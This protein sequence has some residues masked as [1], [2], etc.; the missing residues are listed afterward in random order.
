ARYGAPASCVARSHVVQGATGFEKQFVDI[1]ACGA[2]NFHCGHLMGAASQSL[3]GTFQCHTDVATAN[4]TGEIQ[5]YFHL[6][7]EAQPLAGKGSVPGRPSGECEL[8]SRGP[9]FVRKRRTPNARLRL[10]LPAFLF[11]PVL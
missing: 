7:H 6:D 1:M 11:G 8:W 3:A 4:T 9:E 5:D 10:P 2:S